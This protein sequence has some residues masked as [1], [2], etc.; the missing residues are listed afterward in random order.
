MPNQSFVGKHSNFQS[1]SLESNKCDT[2]GH[3]F[4]SKKSQCAIGSHLDMSQER[5]E[6][7]NILFLHLQSLRLLKF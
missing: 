7:K 1:L 3:G 4:L 6:T 5:Q 2:E